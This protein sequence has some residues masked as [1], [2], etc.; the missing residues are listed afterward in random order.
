[1]RSAQEETCDSDPEDKDGEDLELHPDTVADL[2]ADDA[3]SEEVRGG[4]PMITATGC[5]TAEWCPCQ[6]KYC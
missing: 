6:T 4:R 2:D 3:G 5:G 1:M